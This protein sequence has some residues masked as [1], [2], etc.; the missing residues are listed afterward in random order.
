MFFPERI[1]N[2][3]PN[4]RVLEIGPGAH[5][6]SSSN[7]LLELEYENEEDRNS[8]FGHSEKLVTDK[9]IVFYNGKVFPFRDK[10]FDYVICSHVLEHVDDLA[11]FLGEVFRVSN[12]GYFE[13]P[14][15]YY[16]YLYNFD[17]HVNFIKYQAGTMKFIKKN[18][19]SLGEFSP[20]QQ[21]FNL[22]LKKGYVALVNDLLPL[23]ME[24]FEWNKPFELLEAK[25]LS[26]VCHA[27]LEIPSFQPA[28]PFYV[29]S[30]KKLLRSISR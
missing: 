21:L 29:R 20:V 2:I 14:L 7:V 11:Y 10:E 15:V 19:T 26:E 22:S 5:P 27:Q 28:S 3:S 30:L 12:K 8:Q 6:H 16:D 4:D 23:L 1:K 25:Q 17:V 13:Y 24:G 9:K 18:D